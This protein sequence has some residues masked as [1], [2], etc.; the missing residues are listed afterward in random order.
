MS[1]HRETGRGWDGAAGPAGGAG[2]IGAAAR[3]E[4]CFGAEK[5]WLAGGAGEEDVLVAVAAPVQGR[6]LGGQRPR[7]C[8]GDGDSR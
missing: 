7:L 1:G 4:R 2:G 5:A 8:L 6:R 3:L